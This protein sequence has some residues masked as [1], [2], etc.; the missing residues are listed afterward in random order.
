[1]LLVA[2]CFAEEEI[3]CGTKGK[4]N[5]RI[6]GGKIAKKNSWPWQITIKLKGGFHYCGGSIIKP[7]WIVT[8]AHCF[9]EHPNPEHYKVTAGEHNLRKDEG[10]EKEFDLEEIIKHS[11]YNELRGHEFDYDVALLKLKGNI[12]YDE[13]IRPVCLKTQSFP[14]GTNCSVTGWGYLKENSGRKPSR[15]RQAIVPLV[16]QR[17]CQRAYRDATERMLCAGY[18]QGDIDSCKFDSGG[19]L[20]CKNK[21]GA[22][23]LVGV[24]S[25]G[26][27]CALPRK[28]G[29]YANMDKLTEWVETKI[30]NN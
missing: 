29:V 4:G 30:K 25:W 23:E 8:A 20:V 27:G 17:D 15:L 13:K 21:S 16:S 19:P 22:F 3:K 28:Y 24:V 5:E 7:N 14:S 18:P 10:D 2:L 1:M 11:E 9:E 26:I 12:T 6:V